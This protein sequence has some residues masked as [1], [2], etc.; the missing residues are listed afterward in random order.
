MAPSGPSVADDAPLLSA[1]SDIRARGA[2]GEASLPAA[3]AHADRF[4]DRIPVSAASLV[5]L[6]S[7]GGLPGL[8]L[9]WRRPALP[10]TLVDRRGARIDLLRRAVAA[11]D[12]NHVE[13]LQSDVV[14]LAAHGRRFQVVTARSF[15]PIA[16]TVARAVA[17]LE[18]AGLV[19]VSEPPATDMPRPSEVDLAGTGLEDH[20]VFNGIRELSRAARST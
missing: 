1:L 18:E 19:L 2:I 15:G 5:D 8:V 11:L 4:V 16:T 17:L 10:I 12:L 9:A 20:G 14:D 7:G 6:G 13:V 3:V